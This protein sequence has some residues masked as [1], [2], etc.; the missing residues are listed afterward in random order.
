MA[1]KKHIATYP[2]YAQSLSSLMGGP[3]S[4]D[5]KRRLGTGYIYGVEDYYKA[6]QHLESRNHPFRPRWRN[7]Q[8]YEEFHR[9]ISEKML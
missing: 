8:C 5:T 3:L 1:K 9:V 4:W 7:D 6:K 2:L